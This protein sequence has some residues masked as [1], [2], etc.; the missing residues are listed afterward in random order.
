MSRDASVTLDWGDGTY[1]FRLAWAQ[2]IQLQ[3]AC[4][5]GPQMILQRLGDNSWRV[6]YISHILR[7]G[8]IGGGL[9][10]VKALKLV[11]EYVEARPPLE[12]FLYAQAVL[13]IGLLG[14]PDEA[15]KKSDMESQASTTSPMER[16]DMPP[17]SGPVQ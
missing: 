6:E 13:S 5:A 10:P 9:E 4:D 11:R 3:E 8:L 16:S 15:Q 14:A 1:V 12:N 7:L 17:S 2:L